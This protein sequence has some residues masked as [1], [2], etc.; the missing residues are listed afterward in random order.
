MPSKHKAPLDNPL[1]SYVLRRA[2]MGWTFIMAMSKLD[3]EFWQASR[4]ITDELQKALPD[5]R[6]KPS[7]WAELE[8][9]YGPPPD[10]HEAAAQ[11]EPP[12]G[13]APAAQQTPPTRRHSE[14]GRSSSSDSTTGKLISP[15]KTGSASIFS[16]RSR[17]EDDGEDEGAD[18]GSDAVEDTT[19][20]DGSISN[21]TEESKEPVW[22]SLMRWLSATDNW[23]D[24]DA[25]TDAARARERAGSA[26]ATVYR[27]RTLA[28]CFN[29][30]RFKLAYG[31]F[32][33]QEEVAATD[34]HDSARAA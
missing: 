17:I 15:R 6:F 25:S 23:F 2:W 32:E 12:P 18:A 28:L 4:T 11:S 14:K 10:V 7:S 13:K 21:Q 27:S 30:W 24:H 19:G 16:A 33:R 9:K 31:I 26:L 1:D 3:D 34:H 22:T 29:T 20:G 5:K 8:S